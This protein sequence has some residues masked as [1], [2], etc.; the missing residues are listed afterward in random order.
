MPEGFERCRKAKG[1]RVRTRTLS[2]GRYQHIC[3][4]KGKAYP[5]EVKKKK[6]SS[7][8]TLAEA[9]SEK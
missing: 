9:M 2:G 1:S 5:G 7:G 6:S 4:L 3:Y 8:S